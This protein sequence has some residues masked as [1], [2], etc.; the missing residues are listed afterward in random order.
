MHPF[1]GTASS[2]HV[3]NLP[4]LREWREKRFLS[5]RELAE[6]SGLSTTTVLKIEAG[7]AALPKTARKLAKAL[8]VKNEDLQ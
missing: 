5:Q 6:R 2:S 3:P 1:S 4:R 8:S 7:R